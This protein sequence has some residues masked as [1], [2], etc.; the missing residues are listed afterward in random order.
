MTRRSAGRAS[1]LFA[2]FTGL[3]LYVKVLWA[4]ALFVAFNLILRV[5]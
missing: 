4:L 5:A 3:P 2:R 1:H